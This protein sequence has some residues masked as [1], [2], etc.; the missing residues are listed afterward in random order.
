MLSVVVL[1]LLLGMR[2][3]TDADH[4]VAVATIVSRKHDV[5]LAAWVGALWGL[6]HTVTIVLVGTPIILFKWAVA[7]RV[8]LAMEFAV[9][10]MLVLLGL[11]NLGTTGSRDVEHGHPHVRP[12]AVGIVHGL[13]GSA[14]VALLV[15]TA[16]RDPSWAIAYL[17]VFGLGTVIGMVLVTT[18]IALPFAVAGTG[19]PR[20]HSYL[21]MATGL[22]SVGFG[23]F[24][25]YRIGFVDGLF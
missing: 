17:L 16:I 18:A 22:L 23:L 12:V 4:V 24:I 19:S 15:L 5:R 13:A 6:G 25:A 14:A 7:P 3:A 20:T 2:H 11:R 9:G 1:G 21:R 8:A 10:V